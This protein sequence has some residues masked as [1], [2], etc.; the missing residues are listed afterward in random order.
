MNS[1]IKL[2]TNMDEILGALWGTCQIVACMCVPHDR[3]PTFN[4]CRA[5][6]YSPFLYHFCPQA[7]A[8]K[9]SPLSLLEKGE[10]TNLDSEI[11]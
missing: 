8:A 11:K 9:N 3:K 5:F 1:M 6:L 4:L 7:L 2:L 10:Q